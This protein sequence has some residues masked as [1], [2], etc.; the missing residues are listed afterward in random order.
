MSGGQCMETDSGS[1]DDDENSSL[2]H[3]LS[4]TLHQPHQSLHTTGIASHLAVCVPS[5]TS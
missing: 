1:D 4:Q 3:S 5:V 2:T